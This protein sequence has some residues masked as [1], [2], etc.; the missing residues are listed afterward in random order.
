MCGII[1][2]TKRRNLLYIIYLMISY[3]MR[4]VDLIII[5]ETYKFNDP[6]I[7]TFLM[8]LGEFVGGLSIYLYQHY[9]FKT[10]ENKGTR[11]FG[12]ELLQN[13][14]QMKSPDSNTKILVL[15]FFTAYFDFVQFILLTLYMPKFPVLSPTAESRFGGGI[16]IVGAII[17][18]FYLKYKIKKHQFYYL[19][20]IGLF[21][22]IITIFEI[23][24][25]GKGVS[26]SEFCLAYLLILIYVILVPFTDIIEKY[27]I[28]V[29]FWS[30]F[31][32]LMIEAIFGF[33]LIGIYS[34]KYN[35][36]EDIASIYEESS[37]GEFILLIFLLFIYF[38]LSGIL[39]AYKV[40]IN[41]IFSPMVKTLSIYIL[42][43][44]IYIYY[45]IKGN[46]FLSE[47]ESNWFYFIANIIIAIF[48]SFF[49]CLFNEFLV[50][51]NLRPRS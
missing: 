38:V 42:N 19:L 47:G 4:K 41:G 27:L 29:D 30:P 20:I 25:Q 3:F 24:F 44:I 34:I 28:E 2:I 8:L 49:G 11:Y 12:I 6:L 50:L 5:T 10:K 48:V 1:H 13:D 7:F 45:F 33:I 37:A 22:V 15:I 32:I 35:P 26:F 31:L 16:I 51:S 17:C 46:D 9:F 18:Y 43:P 39:N 14:L 21:L 23:I 36:F 40:L